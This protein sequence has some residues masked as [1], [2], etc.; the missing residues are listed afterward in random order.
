[1]TEPHIK[2]YAVELAELE[3]ASPVAIELSHFEAMAIIS[4]LQLGSR[5]PSV[6]T[7][8]ELAKIA[9]DVALKLQ[10]LFSPESA[11]YKV[12]E[13]GWDTE[14]D[15]PRVTPLFFGLDDDDDDHDPRGIQ[16]LMVN[17]RFDEDFYTGPTWSQ[18]LRDEGI[19]PNNELPW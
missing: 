7:D 1:M 12:L 14:S 10:A 13:L 9:I 5:H 19:E 4:V 8:G 2:Q 3:N 16:A 17:D 11:T 6:A 15:L 18:R